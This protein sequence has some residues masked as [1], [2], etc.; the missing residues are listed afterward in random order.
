MTDNQQKEI[1]R[2][3]N[4]Q[5]YRQ[6]DKQTDKQTDRPTYRQTDR[7]AETDTDR[8]RQKVDSMKGANVTHE[9]E[10]GRGEV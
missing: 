6:T 1:D 7:D 3:I 8:H 4:N 9:E 10:G 5:R 2:L